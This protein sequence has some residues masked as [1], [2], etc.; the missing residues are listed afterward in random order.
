MLNVIYDATVVT[1]A[2]YKDGNRT[3]IFFAAWNI[4]NELAKRQDVHVTLYFSP[5][6][7]ADGE[8]LRDSY[9]PGCDCLQNVAEYRS[10]RSIYRKYRKLYAESG[11]R[12]LKRLLYALPLGVLYIFFLLALKPNKEKIEKCQVFFSP[13]FK[14]PNFARKYNGLKPYVFVYDFIPLVL[15]QYYPKWKAF[16]VRV[17][18]SY[19]DGDFFF[20]DSENTRKDAIRFF[21]GIVKENAAVALLAADE[22]FKQEKEKALV[23]K[24]RK[25]YNVPSEKKYVFSLCSLE[26]RKNV[27][28]I[29]RSF[30]KF[31]EKNKVDNLVLLVGG[32]VW[33]SFKK[34]LEKE[35][36]KWKREQIVQ[37]GYIDDDDLPVLYSNA[38]W[39]VYTSQYEGFGLPPLEA[40]QCGCPVITSN[41]SSL[42]E[43][44]GDAGLL[45]DWDSDERHVEAFEKYYY[46]ET[47]RKENG[48]KG[49]ER[50]KVFSW[51]KTVDKM[52]E[53][54]YEAG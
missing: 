16:V 47:L 20:F 41:N 19:K 38:E 1:N 36:I 30:L 7:I 14:I 42:P 5:E 27:V 26:P 22:C 44:V 29:V 35:S 13:F 25:K 52:M 51:K 6:T 48:R 54:F 11:K 50:A 15:P 49:L 53:G 28:R 40:M 32:A 31:I 39:F 45:I 18:E 21:P 43:V 8:K 34:I 24:I 9:Y 10:L 33:T 2:F 12:K 23:A 3:G 17:M 46:D 4:L 37:T